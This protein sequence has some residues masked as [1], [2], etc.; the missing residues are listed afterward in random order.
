MALDRTEFGS[1]LGR[2]K[3]G[4]GVARV[5]TSAP[6][7]VR[8]GDSERVA[9][10]R[11]MLSQGMNTAEALRWAIQEAD[12]TVSE[13]M[14]ATQLSR[15]EGTIQK[16]AEEDF[17]SSKKVGQLH[18]KLDEVIPKIES[19]LERVQILDAIVPRL[20]ALEGTI[21]SILAATLTT[22][23]NPG[24]D[25]NLWLKGFGKTRDLQKRGELETLLTDLITQASNA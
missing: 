25:R 18:G 4:R 6:L 8:L 21:P 3:G 24:V 2:R 5:G 13:T 7:S 15:I 11:I 22:G 10:G 9:L 14:A 12:R 20:A 16:M 19:V 17:R 1:E 23:I